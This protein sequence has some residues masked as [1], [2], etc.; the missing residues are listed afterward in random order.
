MILVLIGT[1]WL[2]LAQI[3]SFTDNEQGCSVHYRGGYNGRNN[4]VVVEGQ[5]C[6][7]VIDNMRQKRI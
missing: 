3:V 5:Q 7:Q 2:N 1:M 6:E 4:V